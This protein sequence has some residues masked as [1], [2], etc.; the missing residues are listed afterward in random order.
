MESVY[1]NVDG[2]Y[3][4]NAVQC[5]VWSQDQIDLLIRANREFGTNWKQISLKYFPERNANQLKCKFNYITRIDGN[6]KPVA[7]VETKPFKLMIKT[8]SFNSTTTQNHSDNSSLVQDFDEF[9]Y[10]LFQ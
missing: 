8:E 9:N 3:T 5:K 7:K 4:R 1:K 6:Q 2:S 10:E